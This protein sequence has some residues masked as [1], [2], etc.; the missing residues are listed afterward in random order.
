MATKWDTDSEF[1][2][3]RVFSKANDSGVHDGPGAIEQCFPTCRPTKLNE[4]KAVTLS[5][6]GYDSAAR[7]RRSVPAILLRQ[8]KVSA[9]DTRS[10]W[11]QL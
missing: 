1:G 3:R 10:G 9:P 11:A 8:R 5:L 7:P 4:F 2:V 6:K